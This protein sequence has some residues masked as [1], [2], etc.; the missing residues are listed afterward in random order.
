MEVLINGQPHELDTASTVQTLVE[1][2]A[3]A[4]SARGV[5]VALD[6]DVVPR[7][8]WGQTRLGEGARVEIVAAV[9]GG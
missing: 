2:F 6:G 7:S 4:R 5:A 1:S 8:E 3:D 9:Q